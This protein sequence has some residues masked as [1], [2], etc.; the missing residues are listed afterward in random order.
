MFLH[1]TSLLHHLTTIMRRHL[2]DISVRLPSSTFISVASSKT[3]S[4]DPPPPDFYATVSNRG[5][6]CFSSSISPVLPQL[7][8][9]AAQHAQSQTP[10]SNPTPKNSQFQ[11]PDSTTSSLP[12]LDHNNMIPLT[13]LRLSP[14]GLHRCRSR[15][16]ERY[17][18]EFRQE[19]TSCFPA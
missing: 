1:L 3:P 8:Y 17:V 13:R 19:S 9:H 10:L 7:S 16:F 11:T 6:K 18:R 12:P 2:C 14:N 5:A 15:Q 4:T